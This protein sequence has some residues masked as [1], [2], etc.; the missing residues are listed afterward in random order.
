MR[1]PAD[2]TGQEPY[3]A[4]SVTGRRRGVNDVDDTRANREDRLQVWIESEDLP[5][6]YNLAFLTG[7]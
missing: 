3:A 1:P 6:L 7:L 5:L 2:V 4:D